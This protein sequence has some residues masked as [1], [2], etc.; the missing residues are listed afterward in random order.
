MPS[1]HKVRRAIS[2]NPAEDYDEVMSNN[3]RSRKRKSK[4]PP[5]QRRKCSVRHSNKVCR[6]NYYHLDGRVKVHSPFNPEV[7]REAVKPSLTTTTKKVTLNKSVKPVRKVSPKPKPKADV[8]ASTENKISSLKGL[9]NDMQV[10]SCKEM[11]D[12]ISTTT[13]T[14]EEKIIFLE[15]NNNGNKKLTSFIRSQHWGVKDLTF[16]SQA[17]KFMT[18]SISINLKEASNFV[19]GSYDDKDPDCQYLNELLAQLKEEQ[20]KNNPGGKTAMQKLAGAAMWGF[21]KLKTGASTALSWAWSGVQYLFQ[22]GLD[23]WTW[24]SKDPKTAYFALLTLKGFKNKMCRFAGSQ[25]GYF[26]KNTSLDMLRIKY[27]EFYGQPLPPKTTFQEAMELV[28]DIGS[29]VIQEKLIQGAGKVVS[30]LFDRFSAGWTSGITKVVNAIPYVG[31]VVSAGL[32]VVMEI[33]LGETKEAVEFGIEKLAYENNVNNAFGMLFEVIDPRVCID[34]MM[35]QANDDIAGEDKRRE[36]QD[37]LLAEQ[38]KTGDKLKKLEKSGIVQENIINP[39]ERSSRSKE[40]KDGRKRLSK[41]IL[42]K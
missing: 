40:P 35:R 41:K 9:V 10:M 23:L 39:N 8:E 1:R 18:T 26:G 11:R 7:I 36:E 42:F 20:Q 12:Y 22:K 6:N 14:T 2:P 28:T 37:K 29:P 25:L 19:M 38:Q 24:I 34:A 15:S 3:R 17:G 31:P 4:S 5:P 27:N 32:E 13:L 21:N 30:G 16:F 33:G